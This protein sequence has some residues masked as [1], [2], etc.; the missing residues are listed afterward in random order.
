MIALFLQITLEIPAF[1][2]SV[3]GNKKASRFHGW[4]FYHTSQSYLH[5]IIPALSTFRITLLIPFSRLNFRTALLYNQTRKNKCLQVR[6]RVSNPPPKSGGGCW[7]D[8]TGR[9]LR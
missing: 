8:V 3:F 4:F 6:G 5:E 2:M 7:C 9:E 1:Y